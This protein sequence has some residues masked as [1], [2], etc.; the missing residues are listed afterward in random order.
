M[1]YETKFW[2]SFCIVLKGVLSDHYFYNKVIVICNRV[3]FWYTLCLCFINNSAIKVQS[4]EITSLMVS[5]VFQVIPPYQP[6]YGIG[7]RGI[8]RFR[9]WRFGKWINVYVDD[10]LPTRDGELLFSRC[11]DRREF[12]VALLEKAYAK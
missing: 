10:L 3:L 9:F 8:V 6:L 2:T 4:S 1:K 11:S 5:F 12:W 7:Y